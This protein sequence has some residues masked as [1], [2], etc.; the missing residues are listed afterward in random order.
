MR[1][2][3]LQ[4]LR[5]QGGEPF[6]DVHLLSR[7][8][9]ADIHAAHD[10]RELTI[11][12]HRE[13]RYV[14]AGRV[15]ARRK[16]RHATFF[17]LKDRSGIVELCARRDGLDHADCSQLLAADIGDIVAADGFVYVT[18]NHKLALSV[19]SSTLLAKALRSPPARTDAGVQSGTQPRQRDL[20]LL[21]NERRRALI[22]ARSRAMQ[23][24]R[25]WMR[26]SSFLEVDRLS[27]PPFCVHTPATPPEVPAAS[28]DR[29]PSSGG[30]G[31][32]YLRR[33]L[34]GGLERVFEFSRCAEEGAHTGRDGSDF[35]ILEWSAAY[36]DYKAAAR[37]AE[38]LILHVA[39]AILAEVHGL[40]HGHTL[41]LSGP[42]RTTTVRESIVEQCGLD[43]LAADCETLAGRLDARAGT[44]GKNWGALVNALY[45]AQIAPKLVQPTIVYD[46]PSV[47]RAFAKRHPTHSALT[48]SFD[49]VI[50]GHVVLSG[51]S[52]LN[53]PHE[54]RAR[55]TA[56][57]ISDAKHEQS[58]RVSR[59]QEVRLLEYGMCPAAGAGLAVER[60]I[61]LIAGGNLHAG[62]PRSLDL[63]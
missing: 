17:D 28:S 50:D 2:H 11:G 34:L 26:K 1:L 20:D 48:D 47:G 59:E 61:M 12:E 43:V 3:K 7:V 38:E 29:S 37:Q 60:L 19:A 24:M 39:G 52:E 10:P 57:G 15:V 56:E 9:A 53:D 27:G 49:V 51:H 63:G 45:A 8:L 32:L 25:D 36:I 4:Q 23:A 58:A 5:V 22:E 16:H 13:R 30:S 62:T 6:P 41:A 40:A 21:A 42:W 44:R 54:Q 46:L 31:R 35:T 18:D 33:Y 14:V 55:L